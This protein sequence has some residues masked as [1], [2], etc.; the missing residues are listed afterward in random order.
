MKE[1][2]LGIM[3]F[4]FF[5]LWVVWLNLAYEYENTLD[6]TQHAA[7]MHKERFIEATDYC[8]LKYGFGKKAADCASEMSYNPLSLGRQIEIIR[9]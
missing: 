5:C 2:V 6:K 9:K 3:C 8:T 7:F 4:T 1:A